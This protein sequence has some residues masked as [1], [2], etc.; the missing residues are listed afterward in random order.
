M[1]HAT[2][3]HGGSS[4]TVPQLE[5]G[6]S[7][8]ASV[9][10]VGQLAL[11]T[12]PTS[13]SRASGATSTAPWISTGQ[14][15]DFL[16]TEHRDTE[17]ALAALQEEG[18]PPRSLRQEAI[19]IGRQATPTK[20]PSKMLQRGAR[21]GP[22]PIR[23]VKYLNKYRRTGPPEAVKRVTRSDARVQGVDGR[24]RRRCVGIELD[25]TWAERNDS[26]WSQEGDEGPHCGRTVLTP[27]PPN[28]S[29]SQRQPPS[30]RPPEQNLRQNPKLSFSQPVPP[31]VSSGALRL[32]DSNPRPTPL[33]GALA[34]SH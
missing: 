4:N 9:P 11:W 32:G 12:R 30:S 7:L 29:H 21:P 24:P 26:W 10:V 28:P 3:Q 25:R 31:N 20:P 15:I 23:Q 27:W 8:A 16:L 33:L 6:F 18:D 17:A 14:T 34:C 13:G 22:S 1:D 2:I 19:T 5:E